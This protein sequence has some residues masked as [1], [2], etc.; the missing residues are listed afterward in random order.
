MTI[1]PVVP[2]PYTLLGLIL[3]EATFFTCLD[4]KDA[5]FCICLTP[6]RQSIFAFQ[7]EDPENGDKGQLTWARLPQ[8]FKNS[9]TTFDPTLA[10]DLKVFPVDQYGCVLL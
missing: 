3:A 9:P 6:Q 4:L 8:G 7:W 2:N 10:S 1:H 5:F